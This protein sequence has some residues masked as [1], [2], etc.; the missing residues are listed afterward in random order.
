MQHMPNLEQRICSC[1]S[2]QTVFNLY[3]IM[4]VENAKD[5]KEE[6]KN[7]KVM[8]RA[9]GTNTK[10][11]VLA[12]IDDDIKWNCQHLRFELRII[13]ENCCLIF[14]LVQ[15]SYSITTAL[16]CQAKFAFISLINRVD[17]IIWKET[18]TSTA[19]IEE[20]P[21]QTVLFRS[22]SRRMWLNLDEFTGW[23]AMSS[24]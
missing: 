24:E 2:C 3:K 11:R 22:L 21:L 12:R 18:Y 5:W 19:S 17:G 23:N 8:N 7:A 6:K 4:W 16:I 10:T 9:N 15:S 14:Q 13:S 1:S 20:H